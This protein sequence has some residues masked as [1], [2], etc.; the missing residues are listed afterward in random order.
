M[1]P[2]AVATLPR[3][4]NGCSSTATPA[5]CTQGRVVRSVQAGASA[6]R[7]RRASTKAP[8]HC[9]PKSWRAG[10]NLSRAIM[11]ASD[12]MSRVCAPLPTST[13]SAADASSSVAWASSISPLHERT[14]G[15][16]LAIDTRQPAG[17]A[18]WRM[19]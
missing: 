6:S 12:T 16:G 17:L 8:E 4:K 13:A 11:A 3:A 14:R 5:S 2:P 9:A 15:V 19:P 18:R 7:P 10:S 1:Q